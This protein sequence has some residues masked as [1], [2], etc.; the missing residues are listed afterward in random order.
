[1]FHIVLVEP[2]IPQN[3][4]NIARTCAAT[5]A[6]LHLVGP[7]GFSL[8]DRYLKRAGLDYWHLVDV[9]YY[10]NYS[11]FEEKNR[12]MPMFFLTTKAEKCYTDVIYEPGSYL[13]FGKETAG[14]PL[15]LLKAN[16]ERCVR[17]PMVDDARSLNLS[18]AAA[19]VLYEALRQNNFKGLK[20]KGPSGK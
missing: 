19:I 10:S 2:E 20:I 13:V 8:E 1:M 3:T 9:R 4:G 6:V 15:E 14:L 12:G 16:W 11:E 7:L 5:G 17:I 18:N